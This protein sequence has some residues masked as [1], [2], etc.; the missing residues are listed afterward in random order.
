V[1]ARVITECARAISDAATTNAA[2]TFVSYGIMAS[3]GTHT[4]C[5][6]VKYH[7]LV[8]INWM[9]WIIAVNKNAIEPT[10]AIENDGTYM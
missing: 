1:A 6:K 7:A 8:L 2:F 3:A 10:T 5:I 9:V 4:H